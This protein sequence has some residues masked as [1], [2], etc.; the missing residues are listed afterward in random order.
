MERAAQLALVVMLGMGKG[1]QGRL[2]ELRML[3]KPLQ[4]CKVISFQLK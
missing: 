1:I 4:H 2:N 3:T